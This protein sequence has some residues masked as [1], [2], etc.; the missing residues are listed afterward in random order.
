MFLKPSSGSKYNL[1]LLF[2]MYIY[3]CCKPRGKF[4]TKRNLSDRSRGFEDRGPSPGLNC[5]FSVTTSAGRKT[6]N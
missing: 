2:L 4:K 5:L 6:K 1:L 3:Y